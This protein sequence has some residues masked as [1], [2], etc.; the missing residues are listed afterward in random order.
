M[1]T[2][3]MNKAVSDAIISM[4]GSNKAFN[5]Q[6][7]CLAGDMARE[8]EAVELLHVSEKVALLNATYDAALQQLKPYKDTMAKLNALIF[9]KVA[10]KVQIETTPPDAEKKSSAVFKA[11]DALTA[12]EAKRLVADVR[13]TV[14]EAEETPEEKRLREIQ[15]EKN[16]KAAQAVADK[17]AADAAAAKV[18]E[19]FAFCLSDKVRGSLEERLAKIGLRLVVIPTAPAK[20]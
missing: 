13:Q 15:A 8:V 20:K 14:M 11:A 2:I 10:G 9:C 17:L 12:T 7:E 18:E 19:A 4:A 6:L 16:K 5:I 1:K 3:S